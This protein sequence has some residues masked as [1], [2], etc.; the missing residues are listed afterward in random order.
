MTAANPRGWVTGELYW[1][2]VCRVTLQA[3]K[4]E[5]RDLELHNRA[6]QRKRVCGTFRSK[7]FRQAFVPE[8]PK[9]ASKKKCF[10]PFSHSCDKEYYSNCQLTSYVEHLMSDDYVFL[11]YQAKITN[12]GHAEY[13]GEAVHCMIKVKSVDEHGKRRR[14]V[15][16]EQQARDNVLFVINPGPH[17]KISHSSNLS[18][19]E[20]TFQKAGTAPDQHR[21]GDCEIFF[22]PRGHA[23]ERSGKAGSAST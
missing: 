10:G 13:E 16:L 17:K 5:D 9:T 4:T 22:Y 18:V 3:S 1:R 7:L 2:G 6:A 12:A 21:V 23:P 20:E 19:S 15:E 14:N 8:V 11:E